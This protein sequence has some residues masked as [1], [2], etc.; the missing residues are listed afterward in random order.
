M[1][2]SG[3][4]GQRLYLCRP[5]SLFTARLF[6]FTTE[7]EIGQKSFDVLE[8]DE[9][10]GP[11]SETLSNT[12]TGGADASWHLVTETISKTARRVLSTIIT[13]P[14]S[15]VLNPGVLVSKTKS[16]NFA[17]V[18]FSGDYEEC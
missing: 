6:V 17:D 1:F 9:L 8:I 14:R 15:L 10:I 2:S 4:V 16:V 13:P 5:T 7:R 11:G 3:V 12:F 18:N